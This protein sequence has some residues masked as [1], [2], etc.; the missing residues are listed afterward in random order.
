M[1]D[2]QYTAKNPSLRVFLSHSVEFATAHFYRQPLWSNEKNEKEFGPC[3]RPYGHGHNYRLHVTFELQHHETKL[4]H[5]AGTS[6]AE[7]T[8]SQS[9]NQL[10]KDVVRPFDHHHI[11]FEHPAFSGPSALVPT[12]ENIASHLMKQLT[13]VEFKGLTVLGLT[14]HEDDTIAAEIGLTK[15]KLIDRLTA[16]Q[17]LG[18]QKFGGRTSDPSYRLVLK[19]G[20]SY[21]VKFFDEHSIAPP[22]GVDKN[23]YVSEKARSSNSLP[24]LCLNIYSGSDPVVFTTRQDHFFFAGFFSGSGEG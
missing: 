5:T 13:A 18:G 1:T 24:E 4:S 21:Q 12:T 3:A 6:V 19:T 9:L 2:L 11:S 10:L 14:L 20:E 8:L 22:S 23:T 15:R 17:R 16:G 7:L